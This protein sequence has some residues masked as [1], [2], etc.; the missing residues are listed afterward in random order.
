MSQEREQ[1]DHEGGIM[2]GFSH[3]KIACAG[4]VLWAGA[5]IGLSA[6]TFTTLA[7]FSDGSSIFSPLVQ[8]TDGGLYGVSSNGGTNGSG[9]IFKVTTSGALTTLYS[10]CSQKNCADGADPIGA[11]ALG[12][13]G[14]LYGTTGGGGNSSCNGYSCGTVFKVTPDGMF[15]ILHSFSGSDGA[16]PYA[17]LTLASDGNFYGATYG[18][19]NGTSCTLG[20][21]TVFRITA[22]G[23]LTSLHSFDETDGDFPYASLI[24]GTDAELYGTTYGGGSLAG[25]CGNGGCGTI[26]KIS[27]AGKLTSIHSFDFS[28]GSLPLAPLAET[29]AGGFYG[30]TI[31][32]GDGYGTIFKVSSG[33]AF[34]TILKFFRTNGGNPNS[35][36]LQ[37]TDGDLYGESPYAG[38][39]AE[40]E[41]YK[42]TPPHSVTTEYSF[43]SNDE[44]GGNNALL[45]STDGE[46]YGT[47]GNPG[48]I[49]SFDVGLG[50]FVAFVRSTAK[51]GTT[52]QIVG[53]GLTG[54]ISVTFNGV[55]ATSFS[56]VSDT[57]VTA[58]VPS[59]ATTGTVV[60]TTPTGALTSNVNFRVIK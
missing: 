41:I 18:G 28:D 13:D 60:L 52:A 32:G 7:T 20:C 11:L 54:T 22:E 46:F 33:G 44:G 17:G 31:E 48:A 51:V 21:G 8:G 5:A 27:T 10:F 57:Y 49:F 6:Q 26:F 1:Q 43:G 42:L 50:P 40:G 45:Q 25:S 4:F 23:T 59:G 16:Y 14:N 36:L 35:G 15:S 9:S 30:T 34:S 56:V 39:W 24:Q 55:T 19:G 3:C 2:T 47:Y 38:S 58:V 53:Q 37:A 12:T 29:S